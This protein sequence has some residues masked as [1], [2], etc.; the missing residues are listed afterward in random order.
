M[1]LVDFAALC[2]TLF[3]NERG[4]AYAVEDQRLQE[5]FDVFDRNQVC[6]I[7]FAI[8]QSLFSS[9]S[10][11]TGWLHRFRGIWLLLETVDQTGKL[12]CFDDT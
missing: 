4:K 1:T 12:T 9:F 2:R 7:N 8:K 5:M 10:L 3:R 11:I 6:S